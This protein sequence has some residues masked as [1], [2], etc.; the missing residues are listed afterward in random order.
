MSTP[1]PLAPSRGK[2]IWLTLYYTAILAAVIFLH[3]QGN[4]TAPPFVYVG[5]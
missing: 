1:Q 3:A 2:V 4:F 5:F